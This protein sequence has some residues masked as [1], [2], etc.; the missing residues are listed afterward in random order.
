[1]K[2]VITESGTEYRLNE[3]MTQV[4]REGG[5]SLRMDG[6]WLHCVLVS[7]LAVGSPMVFFLDPLEEYGPMVIRTT[8]RVVAI[9]EYCDEYGHDTGPLDS[10]YGCRYCPDG[11]LE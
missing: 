8:S 11:G 4:R 10:R 6:E 2:V 3:N 1:M 9:E 5:D 7:D